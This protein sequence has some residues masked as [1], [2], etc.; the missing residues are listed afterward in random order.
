MSHRQSHFEI[1]ALPSLPG[2]D[3]RALHALFHERGLLGLYDHLVGGALS[4]GSLLALGV[5]PYLS[6]RLFVRLGRAA[7]STLDAWASN[8]AGR[9]RLVRWTRLLTGGLSLVQSYGFTQ[10]ALSVPGVV[11]TPGPAFIAR[12]MTAMTLG[13]L[14]M[15]WM[16]EQVSAADVEPASDTEPLSMEV[17]VPTPSLGALAAASGATDAIATWPSRSADAL[18][19]TARRRAPRADG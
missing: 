11:A 1:A 2:I 14:C 5:L 19:V 10:F 17:W 12:T 6:A 15:L 8:A 4:N 9:R 7:S 13:A 18:P 3:V 16:G